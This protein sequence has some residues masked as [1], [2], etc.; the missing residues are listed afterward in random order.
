LQYGGN[1][2]RF[3]SF[4]QPGD[5]VGAVAA[6]INHSASAVFNRIGQPFEKFVVDADLFW[7]LMAVMD[8]NFSN[9]ANS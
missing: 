7:S 9:L 5:E 1:C 8:N 6:E 2:K 4:H 3:F